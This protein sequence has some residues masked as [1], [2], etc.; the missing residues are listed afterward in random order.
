MALSR[1]AAITGN[2]HGASAV[3]FG[4]IAPL[5][6]TMLLGTVEFANIYLVQSE[7]TAVAREA[8]R[9]L[10]VE[11]MT[12]SQTETF[13]KDRMARITDAI[14]TVTV[15]STKLANERTDITVDVSVE[16][17]EVTFFGFES[18]IGA[19]SSADS[20]SSGEDTSSS[21]AKA[22]ESSTMMQSTSSTDSSG[23][24]TDQS[25]SCDGCLSA[26]ATMIK[27]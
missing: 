9:R 19:G 17:S 26:S 24:P 15:T 18:L 7:M 22:M 21:A 2:E 13:V 27:E 1:A 3:E 23:D 16:M 12:T 8:T 4:L 14:P 20:A 5:L 10:A 25:A 11:A 6:M